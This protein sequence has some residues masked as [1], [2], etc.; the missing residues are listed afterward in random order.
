MNEELLNTL[1]AIINKADRS[2]EAAK[3]LF[4]GGGYESASSRAYYA[5]FHLMQACLLT[6]GLSYSKHSGVIAGFAQHFIKTGIFPKKFSRIIGE[7]R[8]EREIGDY[9]YLEV[10]NQ[11]RASEDVSEAERVCRVSESTY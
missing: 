3:I 2:L 9:E 11:E 8:K 1:K 5:V 4:T 10:I 7:L 6:K